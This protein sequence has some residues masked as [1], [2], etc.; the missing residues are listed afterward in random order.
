MILA[1]QKESTSVIPFIAG[2]RMSIM[3]RHFYA[4]AVKSCKELSKVDGTVIYD[5]RGQTRLTALPK[6]LKSVVTDPLSC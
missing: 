5:A 1:S 3:S 2:I 6:M 4:A